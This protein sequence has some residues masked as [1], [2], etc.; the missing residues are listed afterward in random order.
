MSWYLEVLKK[1]AVFGGRARRKEYWYFVLFN[2]LI[3]IVLAIID[4]VTG[5]F[6]AE[7]GMGVLGGIYT[8][9]VLIP[10][11]AV[12]VRRLHDTNRSGWWL[13]IG[14]PLII[15][16]TGAGFAI[17]L[18]AIVLPVFAITDSIV[19]IGVG[20]IALSVFA[21][22]I[23]SIVIL[24]F[25]VQDSQPG[26]N[27]YGP[28]PKAEAVAAVAVR[29]TESMPLRTTPPEHSW[30]AILGIILV[31][32]GIIYAV[33]GS[34]ATSSKR[35]LTPEEQNDLDFKAFLD[36]QAEQDKLD[37]KT[38][39]EAAPAEPAAS[40]FSTATPA[41]SVPDSTPGKKETVQERCKIKPVMTDHEIEV[42]RRGS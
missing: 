6:S 20:I 28:N 4:S 37:Y 10:G 7:V 9:G 16:G 25:T 27:Q 19:L 21:A 38:P 41:E 26:D 33:I 29:T 13:L 18:L 3:A 11:I 42:C 24:V 12:M 23:G 39:V 2:S 36:N 40:P 32:V 1:Y 14:L 30:V 15:V 31:S 8:L 35:T 22:F 34:H 5:S 17:V